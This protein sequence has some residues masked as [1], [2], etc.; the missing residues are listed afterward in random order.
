MKKLL[1]FQLIILLLACNQSSNN[2]TSDTSKTTEKTPKD[3]KTTV[4]SW[5]DNLNIRDQPS[6]KGAVLTSVE[7]NQALALT[8]S[9][10]EKMETIVLRGVAYQDYW[11]KVRTPD[12]KEGWVFGGAIKQKEE[13]KGNEIITDKKFDFPY[14]GK[15]D[16]SDWTIL[17]EQDASEDEEVD[18]SL[19]A[20]QKGNQ[21]LGIEEWDMGDMGYGYDYSLKENNK[22]G[23]VLKARA[24]SFSPGFEEPNIIS[25]VVKDYTQ[26]P[27]LQYSRKQQIDVPRHQLKPFPLMAT[28]SWQM[29]ALGANGQP[30]NVL[31]LLSLSPTAIFDRTSAGIS[32]TERKALVKNGKTAFWEITDETETKLAIKGIGN[33]VIKLYFLKNKGN[34][35]GLLAVETTNGDIL[36]IDLWK[37]SSKNNSLEKGNKLKAYS[38]NE[39]VT[40]ADKLPDSYQPQ[41]HYQFI[42]DQTV[43]V[44]LY[45]WMDKEFENREIIN[46]IFLKWNGENFEEQ[47]V[48]KE[49]NQETN[50]FSL[51][52]K[53]NYD[54]SKLKHNGKIG[55]KKFWQDANGE[56]IALFTQKENEL[57][58]YHYA[59][60][61]DNVKL[62]RKVYDFEKDCEFDLFLEFIGNSIKVTDLDNNNVGELTFAYKKAC[63][64]DVSPKGL[65][66]LML[67]NGNKFIIR[68]TTT[69]VEP[70][71]RIDGTK[72]VDASFKNAPNSFLSHANTI[73]ESIKQETLGQ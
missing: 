16:L 43:E 37:Y 39:F 58:V 24:I 34:A 62:L 45:T 17:K 69:I 42:D 18:R 38:A 51:L 47:I 21:Y 26:N 70:G 71:G 56:N 3:D 41:L 54:L 72:N 28:G 67:E 65:K 60:N 30:I 49:S 40:A 20:Y 12:G 23:K 66:L 61:G 7:S 15:F 31:S 25:E 8:E 27:P 22:D 14:F 32:D 52:S 5:V 19:V 4:Y 73:W 36:A 9:K 10:S 33:D 59:I 64:S 55:N 63:I 44:Y 29:D 68:G 2:T 48:K 46:R 50:K 11:Y 13:N 6:I 57:F 53:P 1:F 35:D